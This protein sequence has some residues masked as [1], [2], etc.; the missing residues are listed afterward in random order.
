MNNSLDILKQRTYK[1]KITL[2]FVSLASLVVLIT[3]AFIDIPVEADVPEPAE[4]Y[5]PDVSYSETDFQLKIDKLEINVPIIKDVDA[6]DKD[7][8]FSKLENGVAHMQGTPTPDEE[9]NVVIFGHSS[10]YATSRGRYKDI[11]DTLDQ[12]GEGDE[13]IVHYKGKD[14]TYLFAKQEIVGPKDVWILTA[15]FDLTI[16]TC[17]PPG[18]IDNR[19][20]VFANKTH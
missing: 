18:S 14:Y 6:S 13:I 1:K 20:V 10:F 17:W 16:F 15:D 12:L 7:T 2:L 8:Y 5:L 19:L 9:G 11:F 4:V 3:L